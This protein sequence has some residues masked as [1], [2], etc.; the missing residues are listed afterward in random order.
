MNTR[1]DIIKVIPMRLTGVLCSLLIASAPLVL[2]C[3][4]R[5]PQPVPQASETAVPPRELASV[6]AAPGSAPASAPRRFNINELALSSVRL[7]P[8]PYLDIPPQVAADEQRVERQKNF[9]VITVI[10]AQ[11]FLDLEGRLLVRRFKIPAEMSQVEVRR[12]YANLIKGLGG[13]QVNEIQPI[14]ERATVIRSVQEIAGPDVDVPT[15]LGLQSYDEG[16]YV[17]EVYAIRTPDT[18]VWIIIQTSQYTA[19]VTTLEQQGMSQSVGLVSKDTLRQALESSG[20]VALYVNFDVD[21]ATL[22]PDAAPILVEVVK[23][24]QESPALKISVEGHTDNSGNAERNQALSTDRANTVVAA[25]VAAGVDKSRLSAYG[26]GQSK[27]ITDNT[28]EDGR[29]K[30]RRVELVKQT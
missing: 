30:N 26:F 1:V 14:G 3:T 20:R 28:T 24:L 11:Q 17:Y 16:S 10:A 4:K 5:D 9:D 13:V 15:K 27:P 19:F 7:P 23:L 6:A 25:L 8:F 22:R 29:A 18:T 2:G 12:N 21:A